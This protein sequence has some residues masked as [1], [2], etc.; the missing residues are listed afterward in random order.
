MDKQCI[1][2]LLIEDNPGD[3]DLIQF[4]LSESLYATFEFQVATRLSD[5]LA[6]LNTDPSIDLV[7]LDMFLP[8]SQGLDTL[9]A[10]HSAFPL[11]PI[12][13]LTNLDVE[14]VGIEA[15]REG[16]QDYLIKD[17][18]EAAALAR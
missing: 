13:V 10:V 12:V 1:R 5:G 17:N 11:I 8:D 4:V 6:L 16:A 7:L 9:K 14:A 3:I 2:V 15:V 18:F